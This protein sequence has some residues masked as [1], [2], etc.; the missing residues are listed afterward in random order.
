MRHQ[1]LTRKRDALVAERD[2]LGDLITRCQPLWDESNELKPRMN[3]LK[4]KPNSEITWE[5][6]I[7]GAIDLWQQQEIM[8]DI[9]QIMK[10]GSRDAILV[11]KM[12]D[13]NRRAGGKHGTGRPQ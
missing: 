13:G 9:D 12:M 8:H 6:I 1:K 10:P 11:G 5:D 2:R 7:D 3:A 4:N